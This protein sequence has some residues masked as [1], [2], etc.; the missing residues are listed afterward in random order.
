[1]WKSKKEVHTDDSR[2]TDEDW[3]D[4]FLAGKGKKIVRA[5]LGLTKPPEISFQLW[6]HKKEKYVS[7]SYVVT[8]EGTI[9]YARKT[10]L[11][12]KAC[13]V[14]INEFGGAAGEETYQKGFI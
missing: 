7:G 12:G 14:I 4:D 3:L 8:M 1:M 10:V 6:A 13:E 11:E 5:E 9:K 2:Q